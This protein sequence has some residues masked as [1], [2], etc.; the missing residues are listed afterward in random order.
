MSSRRWGQAIRFGNFFQVATAHYRSDDEPNIAVNYDF[1]IQYIEQE[2]RLKLLEQLG[3]VPG[4]R[5]TLLR[6]VEQFHRDQ[7]IEVS[8]V[9]CVDGAA[10]PSSEAAY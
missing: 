2:S 7:S 6:W 10:G 9:S 5:R 1:G 3:L 8:V 4:A